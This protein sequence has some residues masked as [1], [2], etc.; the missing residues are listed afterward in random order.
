M[1]CIKAN[2]KVLKEGITEL[3]GRL[4]LVDALK[5]V[6]K[7]KDSLSLKSFKDKF[8]SVIQKNPGFDKLA[9][10]GMIL[11]G[12]KVEGVTESPG[13]IANFKNAPLV[14]V[15]CE[16]SFSKFNDLLSNK[17][18]KFTEEHLRDQMIIQW[19]SELVTEK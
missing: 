9:K 15:D 7:V 16:R 1:A 12:E 10:Y 8:T 14:S 6:Q 3:E 17:R 18:M 2:L 13:V 4:T 19:N 5:V 11:T